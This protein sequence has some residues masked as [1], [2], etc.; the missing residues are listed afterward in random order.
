MVPPAEVAT[1][2]TA[3]VTV[4]N[5]GPGGGAS[6]VGYFQV[7]APEATVNFANAANS[8]LQ[9]AAPFGIVAADFNE[10]GKP[11]LAIA[12]NIRMYVFLGHG[13][14]TFAPAATSPIGVPSPPYDDFG[15]PY[16]GPLSPVGDFNHSGHLGLADRVFQ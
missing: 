11:D 2:G 6:N 9:V 8:P 5:P 7:A 15:S 12:A 4:V 14:G 3:I 1:A 13:D 16:I 10:D